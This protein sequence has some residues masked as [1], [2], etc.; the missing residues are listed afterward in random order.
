MKGTIVR[1]LTRKYSSALLSLL[2]IGTVGVG[3]ILYSMSIS[4]SYGTLIN[5]T[6]KMR[7]MTLQLKLDAD[8]W[9]GLRSDELA[10]Q[11][12]RDID[13]A[14]QLHEKVMAHALQLQH[15]D[16]EGVC[17]HDDHLDHRMRTLIDA[18]R[19]ML[20][21]PDEALLN[22]LLDVSPELIGM[23]DEVVRLHADEVDGTTEA[24][25]RFII[26]LYILFIAVLIAAW[27]VVFIPTS[28]RLSHMYDELHE[29]NEEIGKQKERLEKIVELELAH[30][31]QQKLLMQRSR[32]QEMG[33][34]M[35]NITH[36]WK[37]PITM[38]QTSLLSLK[39]R[40]AKGSADAEYLERFI[41]KSHAYLDQMTQTVE[42][43]TNYL[44][45]AKDPGTFDVGKTIEKS[46]R[47]IRSALK[48]S[49]VELRFDAP[50]DLFADGLPNELVQVLFNLYK[51]AIEAIANNGSPQGL[52]TV[53]A[54][55][56]GSDVVITVEDNGGGIDPGVFDHLFDPYF[57]TKEEGTGIGLYMSR[58]LI[59]TTFHGSL[60]AAN[61]GEGSRFT[62]TLSKE[63]THATE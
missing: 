34:M 60:E 23:W 58:K 3:V 28:Q 44:N 47:F 38:I 62:I 21:V 49:G 8:Q 15:K 31:E 45:P 61:A 7:T 41:D 25:R 39:K 6:G 36:Q 24:L 32:M 52:I 29:K 22:E 59:E 20:A 4:Q 9:Y 5:E 48:H 33:E 35:A 16:N 42:D 55:S 12:T 51:N 13:A 50:A 19:R 14:L 11:Y 10:Q 1:S 56:R 57:T 46:V 40:S 43:F 54:A 53:T 17:M 63:S 27:Q 26:V 18:H 30:E 2:L 37:Q